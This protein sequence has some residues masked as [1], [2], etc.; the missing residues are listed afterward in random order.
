MYKC[1]ECGKIFLNQKPDYCDCGNDTFV[2]IPD[3]NQGTHN[4][5]PNQQSVNSNNYSYR[6]A[7]RHAAARRFDNKSLIIFTI[8]ILF[9]FVFLFFIGNGSDKQEQQESNPV[10]KKA[11]NTKIPTIDE[12]WIER[13]I[14]QTSPKTVETRQT[15]QAPI[16]SKVIDTYNNVKNQIVTPVKKS[17]V[18]YKPSYTPV[19]KTSSSQVKKSNT[20]QTKKTSTTKK[21]TSTAAPKTAAKKSATVKTQ[22]P[23]KTA[24]VQQTKTVSKP[25]LKSASKPVVNTAAMQQEYANYKIG[26]RNKIASNID[27]AAVVGDGSCVVSFKLDASGNLINRAFSQQSIN[28][29]LNDA[30]YSAMMNT[31][32]YKTPPAGYKNQTLRLSVKMTGG[33]FEVNLY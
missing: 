26:L 24:P 18:V 2:Y 4:P 6:P 29:S 23:V 13:K 12:I 16:V 28:D 20:S 15:K 19:K 1:S 8:C 21:T 5:A 14:A 25:A 30:V 10:N 22:T 9:S 7:V 17:A 31:P 33:N 27:F 3:V 32:T 11:L